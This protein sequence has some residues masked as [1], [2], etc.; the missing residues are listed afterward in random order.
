MSSSSFSHSLGVGLADVSRF[1]AAT[2]VFRGLDYRDGGGSCRSAVDHLRAWGEETLA[3]VRTDRVRARMLVAQADLCNLAGWIAFDTGLPELARVHFGQALGLARLAGRADLIANIYYR[4]GRVELHHDEAG[5]ALQL[6]QLGRPAAH[7]SGSAHAAAI[8][9][10][11]EAWAHANL[12]AAADAERMLGQATDLLSGDGHGRIPGWAAFFTS[13]ELMAMTGTVYTELALRVDRRHTGR[14]VQALTG[15]VSGYQRDMARSRAFCLISLSLNHL[16]G[17]DADEADAV[18]AL[19]VQAAT[20]LKSSRTKDRMRPLRDEAGRRSTNPSA[21]S[22]TDRL[23]AFN[24]T[25]IGCSWV[26]TRR[27]P[28][29]DESCSRPWCVQPHEAASAAAA[30]GI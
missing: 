19:A 12:G 13:T 27:L 2:A 15:A 24:A 14:A 1:E 4:M 11:N 3:A 16:L 7:E 22:L 18:G 28:G 25:L 9:C 30:T 26:P 23:H 5:Q 10:A 29:C 20:G 8:L 21:R 17:S 6:F